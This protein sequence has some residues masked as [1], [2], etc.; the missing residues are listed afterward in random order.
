MQDYQTRALHLLHK[1]RFYPDAFWP[2]GYPLFLT[3]V[4]A[5]AGE[6][7]L[8]VRIVQA[9]LGALTTG[10]T[11]LLARRLTTARSARGAALVVAL[12]PALVLNTVS[13]LSENLFIPLV[14]A[15]LW[16]SCGEGR[17]AALIG[18]CFLGAAMLTRSAGS[19]AI[20]AI[21]VVSLLAMRERGGVER[22]GPA[23]G[24]L[25]LGC[26]VVLTP[27][28][29]RN[30]RLYDRLAPLDTSSGYNFLL[31]NNPRAT[32]RL[33]LS[34]VQYVVNTYWRGV[35]SDL[36]RSSIG[37]REGI[38]Y[39]ASQPIHS[40]RLAVRK[41]QN[42]M[43]VEGREL[44]WAYSEMYL[45]PRDAWLIWAWGIAILLSFP[46]LMVPAVV[47]LLSPGIAATKL[48]ATIAVTLFLVLV[49][50]ALSFGESRYH[51]PWIPLVAILAARAI[52]LARDAK[53]A[54]ASKAFRATG[55]SLG[56]RSMLALVVLF[57]IVTW[58]TQLPELFDR[59]TI[60]A[61]MPGNPPRMGY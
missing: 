60:L 4:Y 37:Y 17:R 14:L 48:G 27:W 33:E 53:Q 51:L 26:A 38:R 3:S 19:A 5:L 31:G 1:G 44:L 15:G 28:A 50:H 55:W 18:G 24:C 21:V 25:L 40:A 7:L 36:E 12:Y 30:A 10:L 52:D 57:L 11:Y 8:A 9:L 56:R 23:F 58:I 41:I 42:L 39:I 6:S 49:V 34:D 20:G 54:L 46:L 29:V 22:R 43:G 45:G 59:L 47:G 2:P 16:L 61:S 13:L 35:K 32:G